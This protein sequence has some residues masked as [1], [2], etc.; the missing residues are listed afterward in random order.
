[1]QGVNKALIQRVVAELIELYKEDKVTLAQQ[2]MWLEILLERTDTIASLAKQ[3]IGEELKMYDRLWEE[4]SLV[5]RIRAE[6]EAKGKL[7]GELQA[8][9]RTLINSVKARFPSLA[10]LAQQQIEKITDINDLDI[11]NMQISTAS[12]EREVNRLLNPEV[13]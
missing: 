10:E 9:K 11:L 12:S 3:E 5:R 6:S 2:I 1:M 4:S 13:A 7:E 8:T